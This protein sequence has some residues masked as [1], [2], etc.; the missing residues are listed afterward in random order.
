M[1]ELAE[2][3]DRNGAEEG[4]RVQRVFTHPAILAHLAHTF[5]ENESKLE[6]IALNPATDDPTIAYLA[7]LN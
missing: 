3:Q 7:T 1:S 2:Q 4:T 6:K 5:V